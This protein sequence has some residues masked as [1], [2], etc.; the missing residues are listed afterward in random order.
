MDLADRLHSET[1]YTVNEDGYASRDDTTEFTCHVTGKLV[2]WTVFEQTRS[3]RL[4]HGLYDDSAA[5]IDA[6][7]M[8][9]ERKQDDA[10][11]TL[12]SLRSP[13]L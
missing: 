11:G 9:C 2:V 4:C 12:L 8:R 7:A 10:V 3:L 6:V 13:Q 1:V 5:A